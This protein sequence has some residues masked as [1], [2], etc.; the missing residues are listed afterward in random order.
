MNRCGVSFRLVYAC[1]D[2][3]DMQTILENLLGLRSLKGCGMVVQG[4]IRRR[5]AEDTILILYPVY[6]ILITLI[7]SCIF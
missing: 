2:S 5:D 7:Y 1:I 4:S 6:C 3:I